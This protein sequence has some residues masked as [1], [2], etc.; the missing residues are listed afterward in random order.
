MKDA[1]PV[2]ATVLSVVALVVAF[3][4]PKS[5]DQPVGSASSPSVVGDCMEVNG[6]STCF[7]SQRLAL[8]S[9]TC[10]VR[11]PFEAELVSATANVAAAPLGTTQY[12][13]GLAATAFATTTSL[14]RGVIASGA[15]G[16]LVASTTQVNTGHIVDQTTVLTAGSFVNLKVGTST[17]TGQTGVCNVVLRKI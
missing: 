14:G 17:P 16:S 11:V 5:A 7:Y 12:E 2:V 4:F 9:T 10:S 3:A 8:A 1:L 13:F 15:Q 6:V